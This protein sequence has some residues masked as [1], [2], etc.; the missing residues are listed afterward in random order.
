MEL[1]NIKHNLRALPVLLLILLYVYT[2]VSKL[3]DY[4]GFRG[5]LHNQSFPPGL[6]DALSILLPVT[7]G[8]ILILLIIPQTVRQGLSGCLG[9]LAIFTAYIALVKLGFWDRVPC[10]CGG[11]LNHM[12][13]TVHFF[14]NSFFILI[15]LLA[16]RIEQQDS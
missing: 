16:I 8:S 15:N 4:T 2:I 3:G 5:Q 13:W 11:I 10:S 12:S 1:T 9:L 14:F 6:A 7:E